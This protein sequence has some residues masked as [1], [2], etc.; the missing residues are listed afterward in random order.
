MSH[1]F[2]A[3]RFALTEVIRLP[4]RFLRYFYLSVAAQLSS[5]H[6]F[7][8]YRRSSDYCQTF[9]LKSILTL[10]SLSCSLCHSSISSWNCFRNF[11]A[12]NEWTIASLYKNTLFGLVAINI[13]LWFIIFMGL[14][15]FSAGTVFIHQNLTSVDV[16]FW[17]IKTV[18]ALKE[19]KCSQWP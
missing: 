9:C 3:E 12:S 7:P 19:L 15:P 14:N 2:N 1:E 6:T 18:H 5:T 11:P 13:V 8:K 4:P 17:R 16:R 10:W